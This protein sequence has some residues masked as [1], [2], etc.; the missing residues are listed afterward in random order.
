MGAQL[1]LVDID[2]KENGEAALRP[3]VKEAR[4]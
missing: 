4:R 3:S 2:E 1:V